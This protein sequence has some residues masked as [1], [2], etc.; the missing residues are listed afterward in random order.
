MTPIAWLT[1]DGAPIARPYPTALGS[2]DVSGDLTAANGGPADY[3]SN[4]LKAIYVGDITAGSSVYIKLREDSGFV[5]WDVTKGTYIEGLIVGV[6]GT[7]MGTTAL[8]LVG[9]R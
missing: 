2:V 7:T 8:K 4:P 9:L 6:G 5:E 3:S 1:P